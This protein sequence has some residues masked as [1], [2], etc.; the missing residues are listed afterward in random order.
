MKAE[1]EKRQKEIEGE[2]NTINVQMQQLQ[3][4]MQ[5]LGEEYMRNKGKLEAY[6][7]ME[8]QKK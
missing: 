5:E 7:E 6:Q 2:V 4:R 1:V 8:D 3:A